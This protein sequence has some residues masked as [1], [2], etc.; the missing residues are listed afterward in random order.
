MDSKEISY[1]LKIKMPS[2]IRYSNESDEDYE[3][4][5]LKEGKR[6]ATYYLSGYLLDPDHKVVFETTTLGE[7]INNQ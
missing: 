4:R 7:K 2:F 1:T 5:V 6:R 3:K